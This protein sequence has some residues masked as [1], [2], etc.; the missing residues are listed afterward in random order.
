VENKRL[1]AALTFVKA[2]RDLEILPPRIKT[3]SEA[4]GYRKKGRK[5]GRPSHLVQREVVAIDPRVPVAAE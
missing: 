5:P 4:G 1:G 2:Q 3:N